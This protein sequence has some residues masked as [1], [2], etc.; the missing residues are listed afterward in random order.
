MS[1]MD[2]VSLDKGAAV[3]KRF[4]LNDQKVVTYDH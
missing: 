3:A 4:A 1:R 2:G